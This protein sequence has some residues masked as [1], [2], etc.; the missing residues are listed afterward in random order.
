M[1]ASTVL[2]YLCHELGLD[3]TQVKSFVEQVNNLKEISEGIRKACFT[4]YGNKLKKLISPVKNSQ[5]YSWCSTVLQL[6]FEEWMRDNKLDVA[7]KH[8]F[9]PVL[10]CSS[11]GF[12]RVLSI[13]QDDNSI[14][15]FTDKVCNEEVVEGII[16][17][18]PKLI[19][20]L[21]RLKDYEVKDEY[22]EVFIV[23]KSEYSFQNN[24]K[25]Q[26][27]QRPQK[28]SQVV[29]VKDETYNPDKELP[30]EQDLSVERFG[31]IRRETK[32][33]KDGSKSVS[34][35]DP[36]SGRRKINV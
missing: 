1:S 28:K 10:I 36:A 9:N 31:I 17:Q 24:T 23:P 6:S 7:L 21:E 11:A 20:S 8:D 16:V 14:K 12:V 34:F 3:P 13:K 35:I 33:K 30:L 18:L 25:P 27:P 26:K 22:L 32:A 19:G 15:F 5:D 29:K 4:K 2:N